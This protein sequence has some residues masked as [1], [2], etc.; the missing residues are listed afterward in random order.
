MDDVAG[1]DGQDIRV[2]QVDFAVAAGIQQKGRMTAGLAAIDA[3]GAEAASVPVAGGDLRIRREGLEAQFGGEAAPVLAGAARIRGEAVAQNLD[4][5]LGFVDLD[6]RILEERAVGTGTLRAVFHRIAARTPDDGADGGDDPAA[7]PV[8]D[9]VDVHDRSAA[10]GR[11]GEAVGRCPGEGAKGDFL[12]PHRRE[13]AH[14]DRRRKCRVDDRS[15]RQDA[16][17]DSGHARIQE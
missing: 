13:R 7:G 6:R 16:P 4:R 2:Q 1:A 8:V 17:A 3:P 11:G 9:A 5:H 15:L 12:N 10:R 14:A